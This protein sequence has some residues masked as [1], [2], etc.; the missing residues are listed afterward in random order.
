[1]FA[2]S[3]STNAFYHDDLMLTLNKASLN[4]INFHVDLK[5]LSCRVTSS[6]LY[7][8]FPTQCF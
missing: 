7:A 2:R 3:K 6:V 4:S 8:E 5:Q 1:M